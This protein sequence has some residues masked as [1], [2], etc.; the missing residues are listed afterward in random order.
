MKQAF[1]TLVLAAAAVWAI[2]AGARAQESWVQIEALPTLAQGEERARAWASAFPEVNGFRLRSGWYGIVLGPF[3]AEEAANRLFALRA[4]RLIPSD[5]FVADGRE[6]A[7]RFWPVGAGALQPAVPAPGAAADPGAGEMP[8]GAPGQGAG[9]PLPEAAALPGETPDGAPDESPAE[10][11]RS[12]AALGE[13]ER[14]ALQTALQWFGFYDAAIDGAF[15][16][17]TRSSMAAWQAANGYEETGILTTRQ[18][19]ALLAAY[20]EDRDAL[21]L[22]RVI[23]TRAGIEIEMP[24][25]LV[26]FEDYAPP[27]VRY[28]ERDGSGVRVLLISQDGTQATLDGLY[29]VMQTLEVVPLEGFRERRGDSFTLTGQGPEFHSHTYARLR[30]GMIKGFT[31]IYP[32]DQAQR[33]AKAI[34]IMQRSLTSIGPALDPTLGPQSGGQARDL[35]SGLQVRQPERVR[36][37]VYVDRS[38]AVLTVAEAVEGCG[39]ITLDDRHEA[40]VGAV[41]AASGLALLRPKTALAPRQVAALAPDAPRIGAQAAVAGFPFGTALPAATL[42][43]GRVEDVSGLGGEAGLLRLTAET[44]EG[45]VGGPVL[46]PAGRLAG[47]LLPPAD[48]GRILPPGVR[49]AARAEAAAAFLA[50]QGVTPRLGDGGDAEQPPDDLARAAREMTVLVSCWK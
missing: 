14:R 24:I 48:G 39:R 37:G 5:S 50:A 29:D 23:E 12:E 10:A 47:L 43:F 41:D 46:D 20:R 25:G 35:L 49:F 42:T 11:R 9:D 18:R 3:S 6:F 15:G 2:A 21:G 44:E 17:G 1:R 30:D 7:G 45:E 28:R 8:Q 40:T 16:R 27:F 34:E 19:E 33:M 31:L 32:P 38:G 22:G 13:E 36:S 26:E 4:E